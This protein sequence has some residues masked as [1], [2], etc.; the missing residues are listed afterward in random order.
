VNHDPRVW[1]EPKLFMPERFL[2]WQESA[3]TF[4][5]QGGGDHLRNHRCAGEWLTIALMKAALEFFVTGVSYT[6]PEQD[7]EIDRTRLPALPRSHLIL[8][9]VRLR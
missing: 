2:N 1:K 3:Y 7:L 8:S 9:N 5:P 6:L 4:I